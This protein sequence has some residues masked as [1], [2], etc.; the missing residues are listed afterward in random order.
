MEVKAVQLLCASALLVR[1]EVEA[2]QQPV[3]ALTGESIIRYPPLLAPHISSR[4]ICRYIQISADIFRHIRY[5]E[6]YQI[7]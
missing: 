2:V 6:T 4:Y 7:Y 1:R 3:L 5:I